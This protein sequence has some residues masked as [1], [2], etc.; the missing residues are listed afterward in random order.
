MVQRTW[1]AHGWHQRYDEGE[2]GDD[3]KGGRVMSEEGVP[4]ERG[5][6]A[7]QVEHLVAVGVVG[8]ALMACGMF[9]VHEDLFI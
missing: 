8:K 3:T 2:R 7:G 4:E 6:R 1:G 9:G 5:C